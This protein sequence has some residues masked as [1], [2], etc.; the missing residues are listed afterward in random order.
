[1]MLSKFVRMSFLAVIAAGTSS[2]GCS[3][4]PEDEVAVDQTEEAVRG[5]QKCG[6][7]VNHPDPCAPGYFC[8]QSAS[9]HCGATDQPGVCVKIDRFCTEQY[10]PVCGCNGTTY[11]NACSARQ[12]SASVLHEGACACDPTVFEKV[13]DTKMKDVKGTWERHIPSGCSGVDEV[14]TLNANHTFTL[15]E[16][17]GPNGGP[18]P[19]CRRMTRTVTSKGSFRLEAGHGVQLYPD[20]TSDDSLPQSFGLQKNCAG[21]TRLA[22][23][24]ANVDVF[25]TRDAT[26]QCPAGQKAC[27]TCGAPP[28]DGVCHSFTCKPVN[29]ECPLLP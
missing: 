28:P 11:G 7:K 6:D 4:A 24:E 26:A 22:T 8:D 5:P 25:L 9:P 15:V 10:Q 18:P 29:E 20:A 21:D 19:F 3:A 16:T 1:M 13:I 2:V 27:A 14:L 17:L 23:T 12:A